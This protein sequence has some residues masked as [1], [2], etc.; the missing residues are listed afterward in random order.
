MPF[1]NGTGGEPSGA[2]RK[3]RSIT[4]RI[5]SCISGKKWKTATAKNTSAIKLPTFPKTAWAQKK[6]SSP[7][8]CSYVNQITA[9]L[10][11]RFKM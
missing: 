8:M 1:A 10:R 5:E 9:A 6:V 7:Q 4:P 11:I 3:G 2:L